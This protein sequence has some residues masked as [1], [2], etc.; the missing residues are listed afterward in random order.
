ME[1]KSATIAFV[2]DIMLGRGVNEEIG[3]RKPEEFWGNTLPLLRS[4][5]AVIANLECA[6]TTHK[7]EWQETP[8]AFYFRADPT[9][10]NVLNVA[11]I[12]CVSLANN[13]TLDFEEEG[14]LDTLEHLDSAGIAHP[15]AGKDITDSRAPAIVDVAGLKVGVVGLTDNEPAFAAG[16]DRPGTNYLEI[17]TDQ[18]TLR[19][20]ESEI[21]RAKQAGAKLVVITLHWG[22]NM[23]VSPPEHF[24][25]FAH[26]VIDLG[27]N[28]VHG[29]S[30]H[31]FQA[32]EAYKGGLIMY[33]TG[34]FLD[35]YAVDPFLRNDWSFIFLVEVGPDG[36]QR[37]RM[38]PVR[39]TYAKVDLAIGD[40]LEAIR[41]RMWTLCEELKT[42]I[43]KRPGG[44]ELIIE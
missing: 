37:L 35:D 13:H 6:I 14:L 7:R 15:G 32:V 29:H 40:E 10:L 3:L 2:G 31:I 44:L 22:P 27:A 18:S 8:K 26:K 9:A 38:I 39:L 19:L 25:R 16:P 21:A 33:D 5:D 34:D 28:I 30:A 24:R 20:V 42:P 12:K 11:N 36:V 4:A 43:N 1:H 41:G 23:V 17:A